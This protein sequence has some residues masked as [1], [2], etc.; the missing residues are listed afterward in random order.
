MCGCKW[1]RTVSQELN[2]N[3]LVPLGVGSYL[4]VSDRKKSKNI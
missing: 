3:A 4:I 1:R 2:Q